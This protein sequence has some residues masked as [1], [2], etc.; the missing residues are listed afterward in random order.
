MIMDMPAKIILAEFQI[1][2]RAAGDDMIESI[3]SEIFGVAQQTS[4]PDIVNPT[5][6]RPHGIDKG[7]AREFEP[8]CTEIPDFIVALNAQKIEG[9]VADQQQGIRRSLRTI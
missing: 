7:K 2:F 4:Q 3:E 9:Q 6:Q 5:T 1:V 8:R